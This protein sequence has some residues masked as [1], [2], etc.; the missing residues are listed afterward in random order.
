MKGLTTKE[1]IACRE[2]EKERVAKEIRA[3]QERIDRGLEKRHR[4]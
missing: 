1:F 3:R 2:R 4:N